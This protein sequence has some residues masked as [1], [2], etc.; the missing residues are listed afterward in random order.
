MVTI[1]GTRG[2]GRMRARAAFGIAVL[3]AM[4]LLFCPYRGG[5]YA[6]TMQPDSY[7]MHAIDRPASLSPSARSVR[8]PSSPGIV[9]FGI[10]TSIRGNRP[11]ADCLV[12]VSAPGQALG[13]AGRAGAFSFDRALV[14]GRYTA[15]VYNGKKIQRTSFVVPRSRSWYTVV[16]LK[17]RGPATPAT[18]KS[19]AGTGVIVFG[20]VTGPKQGK[21]PVVD[22]VAARPL[23]SSRT[24]AEAVGVPLGASGAFALGRR[25]MPGH[26]TIMADGRGAN[27]VARM[28]FII[29]RSTRRYLVIRLPAGTGA[30]RGRVVDA[31]MHP[32]KGAQVDLVNNGG[33]LQYSTM[34]ASNGRYVLR[35]VVPSQYVAVVFGA[36]PTSSGRQPPEGTERIVQMGAGLT[37]ADFTL[38]RL[39]PLLSH[40]GKNGAAQRTMTL[41]GQVLD[42]AGRP[43]AGAT[44]SLLVGGRVHYLVTTG[45]RGHYI[46]PRV[47]PGQYIGQAY[48]IVPPSGVEA[49]TLRVVA[50]R[51]GAAGTDFTLHWIGAPP[52]S[53][54]RKSEPH[55]K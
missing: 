48:R 15:R 13:E 50:V 34:T 47:V 53:I 4:G 42:A 52:D 14:P 32:V 30:L 29:H 25:L 11:V 28:A 21:P 6:S 38:R 27:T 3:L 20:V 1:F 5:T 9:V 46:L 54:R 10:V 36:V 16:H 45:P 51:A 43:V 2:L 24:V 18:P 7:G 26:Y 33:D 39:G 12:E 40:P 8:A 35:Y 55:G 17:V 22:D 49:S 31:G 19:P 44:V 23:E 41:R 37:T